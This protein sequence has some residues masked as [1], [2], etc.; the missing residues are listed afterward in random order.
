MSVTTLTKPSTAPKN[1]AIKTTNSMRPDSC[2]AHLTPEQIELLGAELE[3]LRQQ[4]LSTRGERDA[5]YIRRVIKAQRSLEAA[6]RI[7][8][9]A[10]IFPPAW[11][12][13]TGAL[14]VAKILENMEIGHNILHGQ[15]DWMRDPEIHSTTWEW[16]M[17]SPS[18]TWKHSHNELHHVWTNVLGKDND[19]GYGVIRMDENQK[20]HPFF[21]GQPIYNIIL[22]LGFEYFIAA[23]DLEIGK[24]MKGRKDKEQFKVEA[25]HVLDKIRKQMLKDYVAHPIL[26]GPSF[27][28]TLMANLTA[29]VVRNIWSHT[30][31]FCGHFPD[32]AETFT[33]DQVVDETRGQWYLRQMLGSANIKGSD[34]FHLMAGNLSHQIE[35][36]VF[37]DLPSNRYKEVA[38]KVQEICE[39]YGI[40]Y[41]T[42]RLSKQYGQ[43]WRTVLKLALPPGVLPGSKKP[44]KRSKT[45]TQP[46]A[47]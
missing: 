9:L 16:D 32:G 12:V 11:F 41:T 20:W 47:A 18:D 28:P 34:F 36:H 3:A 37:P 21:L 25:R 8:L 45:Q 33:R 24:V 31:I 30:I 43:M 2:A 17:A 1:A 42:G 26:S 6:G 40:R 7:I 35:H 14:T 4:V 5:Q 46:A 19:V 44:A 15:W 13:G 23:Y 27:V 29:N 22:A 38:P 10:S 39:R